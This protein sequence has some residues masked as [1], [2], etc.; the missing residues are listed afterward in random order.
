M[1]ETRSAR[2]LRELA[3]LDS[4]VARWGAV[5]EVAQLRRTL[6]EVTGRLPQRAACPRPRRPLEGW[7]G[8]DHHGHARGTSRTGGPGAPRWP[9]CPW[10]AFEQHGDFLPLI[11]D[12]VVACLIAERISE[13]YGL[14]LLPPVTISCSH[15]H[16]GLPA[17]AV[18]VSARTLAAIV[19]DV[20]RSLRRGGI[21]RLV[22]VNGH[23]GNYVLQ[24]VVQEANVDG[25]RV[26]LF[27]TGPD[28]EGAAQPPGWRRP[29]ARTCTPG[30]WRRRCCSTPAPT[31]WASTT[32]RATGWPRRGGRTCWS[33]GMGAYTASGVIGR[34]SL[35]TAAKGEAL[36]DSL[37]ASFAAHLRLLMEG[38][39]AVR[40]PAPEPIPASRDGA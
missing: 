36:L 12:T 11:T 28:W 27:P 1:R 10:A 20:R 38:A 7:R 24:N 23:G 40:S 32:R 18:S 8:P 31:W 13:A 25:P 33:T 30:S 6:R 5:P 22:V 29:A 14:F 3:R 21:E 16:E 4:E 35:A 15:E 9:S 17:G 37:T 2:S 26:V 34:P 39:G 19:D